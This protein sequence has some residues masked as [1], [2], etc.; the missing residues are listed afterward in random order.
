[1]DNNTKT[2]EDYLQ[3]INKV[4]LYIEKNPFYPLSLSEMASEANFSTFHFHRIFYSIL[5]EPPVQYQRRVRIE[6]SANELY[7]SGTPIKEISSKYG[8]S[9]PA[10]YSRDFKNHFGESPI[11]LRN[12]LLSRIKTD[13]RIYNVEIKTIPSYDIIY[14]QVTGFKQVIPAFIKLTIALKNKFIKTGRMIEYILDNP[15]ITTKD[16][17]RYEIGSIVQNKANNIRWYNF[18]KT[19]SRL[20]A[21]YNLKGNTN[22]IDDCYDDIFSWLIKSEYEPDNYPLLIIFNKMYSVRPFLPID[23]TN[24]DICVPVKRQELHSK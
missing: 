19:E 22:K 3:R 24:A 5:G 20:Y 18:K 1:M 2:S 12:K 15:Y 7:N 17:C 9:S 10:V 8:F 11:A 16:K 4:L 23:Y 13:K 21:V 6:N 14:T